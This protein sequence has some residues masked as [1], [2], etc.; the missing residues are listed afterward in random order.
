M[1]NGLRHA[2]GPI[3][4]PIRYIYRQSIYV[5]NKYHTHIIFQQRLLMFTVHCVSFLFGALMS[6]FLT[7]FEVSDC[8]DCPERF[9]PG[10]PLFSCFIKDSLHDVEEALY[11]L[12]APILRVLEKFHVDSVI[13]DCFECLASFFL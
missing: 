9:G 6:P 5:T 1:E 8:P 2:S 10:K 13:H 7:I 3:L 4:A 12:I 11:L